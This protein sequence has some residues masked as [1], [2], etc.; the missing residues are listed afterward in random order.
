MATVMDPV[1]QPLTE[2]QEERL[3]VAKARGGDLGAY[4]QFDDYMEIVVQLGYVTLF[5]SAYPLASLISIA[6]NWVEIRA[7]CFKLTKVCRRP[8]SVR[9]SGL[10]MWRTLM[11]S[12]IWTSALTNCLIAGFTSRQLTH[13]MPD[14]YIRDE[15]GF[16]NNLEHKIKLT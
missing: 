7:D 12:V 15:A 16:N 3:L 13:Y 8:E 5:A 4:D 14:M 10:G 9:S 2:Q 6:A 11:A 1:K